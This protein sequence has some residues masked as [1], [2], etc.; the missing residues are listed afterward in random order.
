MALDAY[1]AAVGKGRNFDAL[2]AAGWRLM[3]QPGDCR[4]HDI[5]FALDNGAYAAFLRGE[6]LDAGVFSR[7]VDRV[8][9][10][11]DFIVAPDIVCGGR[12]SLDLSLSWLDQLAGVAPV[13][14]AVQDGFTDAEIVPYLSA[15]VG[16]FVGGSTE[17]KIANMS[18][19]G[20][21]ARRAGARCH[22]GRV[23]SV[24]RIRACAAAGVSS[25]DGS[26]VSRYSSELP[27]L[28]FARR[29]G[30]LF[31]SNDLAAR[32]SIPVGRSG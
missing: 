1:A 2:S 13:L 8:G 18:R 4:S 19:W 29:Q 15:R 12:E 10:R 32:S 3:Y 21:L 30:D 17:W 23:N 27:R 24:R 25:F 6:R 14:I 5:G 11:A 22:V 28:D 31:G 20:L 7:A 16:V 26:G 9:H